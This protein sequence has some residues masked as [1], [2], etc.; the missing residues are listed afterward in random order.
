MFHEDPQAI[1]DA[2]CEALMLTRAGSDIKELWYDKETQH[3]TVAYKNGCEKLINVAA[4][5]GA[6]MIRDIMKF[7]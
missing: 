1:C 3:V 7:I 2:L 4:D 5:S 6:A